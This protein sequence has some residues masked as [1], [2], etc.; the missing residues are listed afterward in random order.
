MS[1]N[2]LILPCDPLKTIIEDEPHLLGVLSRFGL[3]FGFGDKTVDEACNEDNVH[4]GSFLAVSNFLYGQNYSQ[5]E[6]SLPAL[7]GYLRKAHTHFLNFLLP[8]IRRKLIEA[9]NYSD[10][11]DVA[12]LL[13]KFYDEYVQE[14]HNHMEHEND[15]VFRYVSDLLNG[16]PNEHFRIT[17][18]SSNHGSMTEKLSQIKNL[19]IRHYHVKDN[20]VLTSALF[21]IIYC[22]NELKNH[23]DIENKLFIPAVEKLEKSLK[24]SHRESVKNS[25]SDNEKTGLLDFMTD[26]E[27][28]II[29]CVAKG[30]S[31]KEIA[32][33]L[34]ISIHTVTT[35]RRNISSKLQIHSTAGLTVFAILN[36]L[37]D[38]KDVNPHRQ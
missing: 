35:Y 38:I 18:Y 12:F 8:A 36:D 22:G 30:L 2:R 21:D 19:F 20:E 31:N 32:S 9:I 14:V 23:C 6:I 10:I 15:E 34:F 33:Q 17:D 4:M 1:N 25:H 11:D 29:R 3:S 37:V 27:K 5:F 24:L 7:M 13:L 26:R 28:D 16:V